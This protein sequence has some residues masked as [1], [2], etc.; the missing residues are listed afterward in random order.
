MS[1]EPLWAMIYDPRGA[2]RA[3]TD[4][5]RILDAPDEEIIFVNDRPDAL[6]KLEERHPPSAPGMSR[7]DAEWFNWHNFRLD[8]ET[9]NRP[10]HNGDVVRLLSPDSE[11]FVARDIDQMIALVKERKELLVD[12]RAWDESVHEAA[13][14]IRGDLQE[15]GISTKVERGCYLKCCFNPVGVEAAKRAAET[16][17]KKQAY[18]NPDLTH[19]LAAAWDGMVEIL[20]AVSLYAGEAVGNDAWYYSPQ[21]LCENIVV[22]NT[23]MGPNAHRKTADWRVFMDAWPG[24]PWHRKQ[25]E[26]VRAIEDKVERRQQTYYLKWLDAE[27]RL[28][29]ER[30]RKNFKLLVPNWRLVLPKEASNGKKEKAKTKTKKAKAK[31][32][33]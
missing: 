17:R 10:L 20:E 22:F 28:P 14:T 3:T 18:E 4:Q 5:T 29:K 2:W 12:G 30:T 9:R 7:L 31:A 6:F 27:C 13:R 33:R 19:H 32:G 26:R 1:D 15:A 23:L 21:H 25:W 24:C 16:K 11:R 8:W